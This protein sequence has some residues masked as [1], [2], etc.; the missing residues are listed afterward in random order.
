MES[1]VTVE[2]AVQ[3]A[4][5]SELIKKQNAYEETAKELS[6]L[7]GQSAESQKKWNMMQ[8]SDKKQGT[9]IKAGE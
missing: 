8:K 9:G 5:H 6:E 3:T 7:L 4:C 1:E 2:K